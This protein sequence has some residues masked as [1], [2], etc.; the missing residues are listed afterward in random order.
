VK[1]ENVWNT[2]GAPISILASKT[3]MR[4]AHP[5]KAICLSFVILFPFLSASS[6]SV[7]VAPWT[8]QYRANQVDELRREDRLPGWANY[9]C[10][11]DQVGARGTFMLI[12]YQQSGFKAETGY[13][14]GLTYQ[15]Y[16]TDEKNA[17]ILPVNLPPSPE[18]YSQD[19]KAVSAAI[20]AH[21]DASL[22]QASLILLK[23]QMIAFKN[24]VADVKEAFLSDD[25]MKDEV[26]QARFDAPN[27]TNYHNL[28]QRHLDAFMFWLAEQ[29]YEN[30]GVIPQSVKA[31]RE[32]NVIYE[33]GFPG[34][35]TFETTA[36]MDEAQSKKFMNVRIQMTSTS[37][38]LRYTQSYPSGVSATEN[39]ACDPI[40][41][42][43]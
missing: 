14:R 36:G 40:G 27:S 18:A 26:I 34:S 8:A 32:G 42:A 33:T 29:K 6:Q 23:A 1:V 5:I 35:G 37:S 11:V 13:T 2:L 20:A 41:S 39:G 16:S 17:N 28:V 24:Q 19:I 10:G 15:E 31:Y 9:V 7:S 25:A 38:G 43:Q 30:A 21:G 3:F 12:A 4:P 22:P